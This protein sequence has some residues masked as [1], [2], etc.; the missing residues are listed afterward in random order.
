MFTDW[1]N[2]PIETIVIRTATMLDRSIISLIYSGRTRWPRSDSADP[3]TITN[4]L[5]RLIWL[6]W[7]VQG[8]R[9][10]WQTST[11]TRAKQVSKNR[12][13]WLVWHCPSD[14]NWKSINRLR[15]TIENCD[16][17][18]QFLLIQTRICITAIGLEADLVIN[19]WIVIIEMLNA[20]RLSL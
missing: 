10:S 3:W 16:T 12:L 15:H 2:I 4:T 1:P 5:P 8:S 20:Q 17:E 19:R 18:S 11:F 9:R 7:G 6:T 13:G 14:L